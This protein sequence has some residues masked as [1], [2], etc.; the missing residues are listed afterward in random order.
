MKYQYR[1]DLALEEFAQSAEIDSNTYEKYGC[2]ISKMILTE[3]QAKP[4]KKNGGIYYTI[5]TKAFVEFDSDLEH[6]CVKA[7][8]E[9]LLELLNEL[10]ITKRDEVFVVGLG[11]TEITPDALGPEVISKL[12]VTKHLLKLDN[13]PDNMGVVS[14]LAPGVMGQTGIETSDIIKAIIKQEKPKL[15]IVIDALAARS[16]SRINQSIQITTSGIN[17]GSGVG[18]QRKELSKKTL[19]CDVIAIGVPTVVDVYNISNDIIENL[20]N[21]LQEQQINLDGHKE[22][23][24]ARIKTDENLDFIVTP[25]EI[26][27]SIADLSEVISR[28]LNISLHN[29]E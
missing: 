23:M 20:E 19:G 5:E 21:Y 7:I 13:L 6:Q 3:E 28:A 4:Y 17:P 22:G 25:K 14:A 12:I 29:I 9:I 10:G 16:I 27:Q 2:N 11:N 8:Q 15:I 18:N 26:D 24:T 1:T